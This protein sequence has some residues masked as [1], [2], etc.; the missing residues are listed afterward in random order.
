MEAIATVSLT[1][2]PRGQSPHS[3]SSVCPTWLLFQGGTLH[4]E[5]DD[6]PL[7][8]SIQKQATV[9]FRVTDLDEDALRNI[10]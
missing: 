8:D 5:T 9:A 1:R 10:V 7:P 6:Q 4:F 2:S 3:M